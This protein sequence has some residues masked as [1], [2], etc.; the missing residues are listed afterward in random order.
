[1]KKRMLA[2][3]MSLTMAISVFSSNIAFADAVLSEDT[4]DEAVAM[5]E[6]NSTTSFTPTNIISE[7]TDSFKGVIADEKE[8]GSVRLVFPAVDKKGNIIVSDPNKTLRGY[9]LTADGKVYPEFGFGGGG[10]VAPYGNMENGIIV[11]FPNYSLDGSTQPSEE[12][13]SNIKGDCELLVGL[14]TT[15]AVSMNTLAESKKILVGDVDL[16]DMINSTDAALIIKSV[17]NSAFA[18]EK[19]SDLYLAANVDGSKNIDSTDAALVIKKATDGSAYTFPV[20]DYIDGS[21]DAPVFNGINPDGKELTIDSNVLN[22]NGYATAYKVELSADNGQTWKLDGYQTRISHG[23][24]VKRVAY[25]NTSVEL[26]SATRKSGAA[27][28]KNEDGSI[29]FVKPGEAYTYLDEGT[30][31]QANAASWVEDAKNTF[32]F[33]DQKEHKLVSTLTP[34][35]EYLVKV[36]AINYNDMNK[37]GITPF[38][39]FETKLKTS[40]GSTTL[41]FPTIEGGGSYSTGGRG[42]AATQGDVYIVTNLDDS[43][44][45][46]QPGSFRYGLKRLDREDKNSSYPRT[47]VFAVGGTIHIDDTVPKGNRYWD[48]SSNTTIMGQTAPGEG[49][50]LAGG[51][52]N[53]SGDNI[54]VRYLRG[55][56]GSGYDRDGGSAS[57]NNIVIDHCTFSWGVDEGFSPK[58][59]INSSMQYCIIAN[60]LSIV[61]KNGVNNTD[62]ELLSGE[63]EAKHGMATITNGYESSFTH[64]LYA[65]CGTRMPRFEG[66]FEYNYN[67]YTN[68][69]EFSNNVIYNWGHNS[70]YGGDRGQAEVNFTNNYYKP[71]VNTLEKVKT[72]IFDCDTDGSYGNVKS[73]YYIGGN[74]M[75]S[76][77]EVTADNTKGFRDLQYYANQLTAPVNLSVDYTAENANDA[78]NH[79]LESVGASY[80]RDAIDARLIEDVKNG[81]GVH[82]NDQAE[83]GGWSDST[84][85]STIVDTDKDGMPDEFE[86]TFGTNPQVADSTAIIT[87][88]SSKYLGY[89]PLEVYCYS[90][91]GEWDAQSGH[92]L[93][94]D[95]TNPEN[96][97]VSIKDSDNNNI[98][99][100]NTTTLYLGKTYTVEF[101]KAEGAKQLL[102]NDEVVGTTTDGAISIEF[103]PDKVGSYNLA[104]KTTVNNREGIS[105]AVPVSIVNEGNIVENEKAFNITKQVGTPAIDGLAI[106][107]VVTDS[108]YEIYLQG[109]GRIG[110]TSVSSNQYDDNFFFHGA[111]V[112]GDVTIVAKVDNWAKL[113]YYQKAGIMFRKDL[114]NATSE[115]FMSAFSMLKGESYDGSKDVIG[116]SI[117]ARNIMTFARTADG[118]GVVEGKK[119]SVPKKRINEVDNYGWM[120]VEKLGNTVTTYAS[121]D[122]QTWYT[123]NSYT[124]TFGDE[125][126]VGFALDGAQ[127]TAEKINVNKALFTDINII[128]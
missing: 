29:K 85:T 28:L 81:T 5:L 15:D 77:A 124:C 115:F 90:L 61:N 1:M 101:A 30:T 104:F 17:I 122:G 117:L 83:A 12:K 95:N 105:L 40:P 102:V 89:T 97:I 58:G 48:I 26:T 114:D 13:D 109:S 108:G 103:T 52:V 121:L 110:S 111:K 49:I 8:D 33:V 21:N 54:I 36:S 100:T 94:T 93:T 75:E 37:T 113:D 10:T 84:W 53:I 76:S 126:Y 27:F 106:D 43:V 125:Y 7:N 73:S 98:L 118:N 46:P 63:S 55:R 66:S 32:F 86:T 44:S 31:T 112:S 82:I 116:G 87:D 45:N 6:D 11:N 99:N 88:E 18:F 65:N 70:G 92:E 91:L 78:Y 42:S 41:A 96:S 47:I 57:G 22:S 4:L 62:P 9:N 72:Q 23:K 59:L 38:A 16:N 56:L 3:V 34:D 67:K 80:V 39:T 24:K 60:G 2:I 74:V 51:T 107:R 68:R 20:G 14:S 120:K 69:M 127:D 71:G 64:N 79:V 128:R 123:L 50:T 35:T 25:L 119:L 19:G